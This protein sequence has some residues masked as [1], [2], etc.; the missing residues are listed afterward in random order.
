MVSRLSRLSSPLLTHQSLPF[1]LSNRLFSLEA[2][3]I[4]PNANKRNYLLFF[5]GA[6]GAS[7]VIS[8]TF[9]LFQESQKPKRNILLEDQFSACQITKITPINHDT[10]LYTIR[11]KNDVSAQVPFH[12]VIKD[13][14]CQIARSGLV[15][16]YSRLYSCYCTRNGNWAFG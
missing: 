9:L 14:S 5:L 13:D 16:I 8:D 11:A 6:L 3:V 2:K 12:I 7:V 4:S 10:K 1:S 15:I